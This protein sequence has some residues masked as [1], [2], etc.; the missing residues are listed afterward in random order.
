MSTESISGHQ[1]TAYEHYLRRHEAHR[2]NLRKSGLP[3]KPWGLTDFEE[4]NGHINA[5]LRLGSKLAEELDSGGV[6]PTIIFEHVMSSIE[7]ELIDR[8]S[9]EN[10]QREMRKRG[11]EN[12]P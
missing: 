11:L 2:E 7:D 4:I 6:T 5:L 10:T 12:K 1:P 8:A 9:Q 3:D